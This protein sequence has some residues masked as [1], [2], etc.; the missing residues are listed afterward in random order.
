MYLGSAED[1]QMPMI[2][3]HLTTDQEYIESVEYVKK[4]LSEPGQAQR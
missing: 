1:S 4:R 3:E 2:I